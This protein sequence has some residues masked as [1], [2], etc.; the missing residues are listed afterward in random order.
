MTSIAE[1]VGSVFNCITFYTVFICP[2]TSNSSPK[3]EESSLIPEDKIF[4][5]LSVFIYSTVI[6][7]YL[8]RSHLTNEATYK[9]ISHQCRSLVTQWLSLSFPQ[10][11]FFIVLGHGS[12]QNLD[13]ARREL[14]NFSFP[15]QTLCAPP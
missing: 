5:H 6:A 9:V 14:I 8:S 12:L 4:L 3:S 11:V 13:F 2:A 7:D 15:N 1:E 10:C